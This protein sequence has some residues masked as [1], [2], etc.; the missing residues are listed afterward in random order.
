MIERNKHV[1]IES[2]NDRPINDFRPDLSRRMLF[3]QDILM[4]RSYN[5]QT[6]NFIFSYYQHELT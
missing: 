3:L 6:L 1:Y 5:M 2:E 4:R